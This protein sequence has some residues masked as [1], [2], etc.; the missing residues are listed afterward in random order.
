MVSSGSSGVAGDSGASGAWVS[1]SGGVTGVSS[2]VSVS[3]SG[4]VVSEVRGSVTSAGSSTG[5]LSTA[6]AGETITIRDSTT[7]MPPASI[8]L[9]IIVPPVLFG[10]DTFIIKRGPPLVKAKC[11]RKNCVCLLT[12]GQK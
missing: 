2:P 9:F 5:P 8:L 10:K 12:T 4:G 11:L 1:W 3:P 6:R 7:A